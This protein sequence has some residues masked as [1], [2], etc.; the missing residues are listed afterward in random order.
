LELIL[1]ICGT[2]ILKMFWEQNFEKLFWGNEIL[3]KCDGTELM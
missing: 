2:E 1:K 3:K